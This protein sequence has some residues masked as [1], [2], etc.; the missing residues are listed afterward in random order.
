MGLCLILCCRIASVTLGTKQLMVIVQL[1]LSMAVPARIELRLGRRG[2]RSSKG[3]GPAIDTGK[4]CDYGQ[5]DE[6]A[7]HNLDT[8]P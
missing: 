4:E 5:D 8:I 7:L 1:N 2:W 6:N 3:H